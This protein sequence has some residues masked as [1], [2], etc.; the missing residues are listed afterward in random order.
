V[1][2]GRAL[3][4]SYAGGTRFGRWG[5]V[6]VAAALLPRPRRETVRVPRPL[7]DRLPPRIAIRR[8]TSD[9]EVFEDVLVRGE[10]DSPELRRL[11]AASILDGGAN[12]GYTTLFLHSVFPEARIV[13]VE[14]D[15]ENVRQLRENV[16]LAGIEDLVTCVH[17]AVWPQRERVSIINSSASEWAFRVAP[18][19]T[20]GEDQ[21][22]AYRLH[23]LAGMTPTGAFDLIKLDI[24]GA[25]R[26]LFADPGAADIVRRAQAV[27]VELHD[28]IVSGCSASFYRSIVGEDFDQYTRGDACLVVFDHGNGPD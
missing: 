19:K 16:R 10:Y 8:K 25:E 5:F 9:E 3:A 20:E 6:F 7:H 11:D 17:G 18:V 13:A 14:P 28:R 23:D 1:R 21:I 2:L 24:E 27:L 4:A 26:E 15:E 12:V 22:E